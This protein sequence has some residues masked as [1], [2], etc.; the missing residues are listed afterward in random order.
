ML[1]QLREVDLSRLEP[2]FELEGVRLE[3]VAFAAASAGSGRFEQAH[4][5]SWPKPTSP[6]PSS[7]TSTCAV[8]SWRWPA[9]CSG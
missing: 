2:E 4:F 7:P 3:A 1:E 8:P 9:R 6:R 5:K